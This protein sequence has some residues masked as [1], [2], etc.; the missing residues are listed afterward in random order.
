MLITIDPP[1]PCAQLVNDRSSNDSPREC[2]RPAG[3]ALVS[4]VPAA[5]WEL[6]PVCAVHLR[7]ASRDLDMGPPSA[8]DVST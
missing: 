3:H 7:E 1:L 6:L 2:G 4:Q 5:A 8:A